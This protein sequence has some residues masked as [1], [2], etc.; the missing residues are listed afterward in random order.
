[1]LRPYESIALRGG[2]F[3]N[4]E[5]NL[6]LTQFSLFQSVTIPARSAIADKSSGIVVGI[7]PC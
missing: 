7:K 1:M 5:V 3:T 4:A 6:C 2:V